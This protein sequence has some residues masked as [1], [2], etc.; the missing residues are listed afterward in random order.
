MTD[1]LWRWRDAGCKGFCESS[2]EGRCVCKCV[3][4]RRNKSLAWSESR[5]F[6]WG[7]GYGRCVGWDGVN[8]YTN[9]V[10]HISNHSVIALEYLKNCLRSLGIDL[11]GY[12]A[13]MVRDR[14]RFYTIVNDNDLAVNI[15]FVITLSL[16][17][18]LQIF[19]SS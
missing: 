13:D 9:I 11:G 16:E 15:Q 8:R 2:R 12:A 10:I 17:I 19:Q 5:S 6:G 1:R 4:R 7:E 18:T 14:L 3:G